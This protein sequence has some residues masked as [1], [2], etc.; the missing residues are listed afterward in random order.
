MNIYHI[1]QELLDIFEELEENGGELTP[2]L[3]TRLSIAQEDFK[4]K[5]E[6]YTH[7]I[8]KY[9]AD[10]NFI[11]AEQKRLKDLSDR[12]KKVVERLTK[13]MI[14]AIDKFGDSKKNSQSKFV[15]FGTGV[16]S[17]RNSKAVELDSALLFK[18]NEAIN[19]SITDCII[20]NQ[21]DVIDRFDPNKIIAL[22]KQD[23]FVN[24]PSDSFD[25]SPAIEASEDDLNYTDVELTVKVPLK[26]IFDGKSYPVIR[27][28]AKHAGYKCS[29]SASKSFLKTELEKN[30]AC[31]PNLAR[32]V[33]NKSISIK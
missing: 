1:E 23:N 8:A 25:V 26:E 30:G 28:V 19:D 17:I 10:I 29:V 32:I 16:V 20:T 13:V 15:D 2:E 14:E 3:E 31:A 4:D 21:L 12:K 24:E 18:L 22:M 9:N 7:V 5:I 6:S 33:T 11:K 27:E